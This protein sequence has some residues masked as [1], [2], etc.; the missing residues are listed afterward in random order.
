MDEN[1]AVWSVGDVAEWMDALYPPA[2]KEDW[3]RVGLICGDRGEAVTKILLAVDPCEAVV[4]EALE[5]GADMVVTHHPLFLRGTSFVSTDTA[6]GRVVHRL[7]RASVALFNA[8]TN[9][10]SARLGVAEALAEAAGLSANTW[11][12]LQPLRDHPELGIGRVGPLSQP[13]TVGEIA[14][15]LSELLPASP[16]GILI[17]GDLDRQVRVLAVSGGSGQSLLEAARE[18]GADAFVTADLRHH[19]ASDFLEQES[20]LPDTRTVRPAPA[21]IVPS[22]WASEWLWLGKLAAQLELCAALGPHAATS[23][24]ADYA[25]NTATKTITATTETTGPRPRIETRISQVISE[26]WDAYLPTARQD[27]D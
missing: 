1:N 25:T 16:A 4:D 20:Y 5:W 2:L 7:I 19:P 18:A 27:V 11:R 8:H 15:R 21:L 23:T 22:H 10:D 13:Y 9:A 17:G 26:P 24:G 6:K 3:D 14:E 12:P